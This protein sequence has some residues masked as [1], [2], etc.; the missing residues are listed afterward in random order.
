ME[1]IT[2]AETSRYIQNNIGLNSVKSP[3]KDDSVGNLQ[4]LQNLGSLGDS[5]KQFV[6]MFF[7]EVSSN[8]P[9]AAKKTLDLEESNTNVNTNRKSKKDESHQVKENKSHQDQEKQ[10]RSQHDD[11]ELSVDHTPDLYQ[12]VDSVLKGTEQLY[13]LDAQEKLGSAQ[14]ISHDENQDLE[15]ESVNGHAY[16]GIE[17][18]EDENAVDYSETVISKD[19]LAEEVENRSEKY[20]DLILEKKETIKSEEIAAQ[21]KVSS[22]ED[23]E[24]LKVENRHESISAP[25]STGDQS[26]SLNK[27]GDESAS[28]NSNKKDH[29]SSQNLNEVRSVDGKSDILQAN[30]KDAVKKQDSFSKSIQDMIDKIEVLA[31]NRKGG[32]IQI[33]L[34]RPD[35]ETLTLRVKAFGSN[36][37]ASIISQNSTLK[38]ELLQ[39]K[40]F[41]AQ[42]LE[43]RG[44][45]L[46]SFLADND[47]TNFHQGSQ[48]R[49][50][51]IYAENAKQLKALK[52]FSNV[53]PSDQNISNNNFGYLENGVD[54]INYLA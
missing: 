43:D 40:D 35:G 39:N 36:I 19:K 53:I 49:D 52:Q 48:P 8:Q 41:L 11:S 9:N 32:H 17:S 29:S 42:G 16:S 12:E 33:N 10:V 2:S 21:E 20:S 37:E 50:E 44:F 25:I 38:Q 22:R 45:N 7:Q 23:Q 24:S 30:G 46:Q 14:Y 18:L 15:L 54:R 5:N 1:K 34:N 27:N 3:I 6:D 31:K 4:L 47:T 26:Q 51:N 28:N 13:V